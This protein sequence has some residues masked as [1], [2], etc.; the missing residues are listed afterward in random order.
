MKDI[1]FFLN[2]EKKF[3]FPILI[4]SF[5]PIILFLGS[6]VINFFIILLDL[7]FLIEIIKNK[8]LFLL[9][10][11][12]FYLLIVFWAILIINLY[13]SIDYQNSLGRSLGFI[14][15]IILIF[16]FQYY[17]NY[18]KCKYQNIVFKTWCLTFFIISIDLIYEFSFGK[19]IFGYSS[20]MPGRLAGFFNEELKIGYLYSSLILF[21][22]SYLFILFFKERKN[23]FFNNKNFFYFLIFFSLFVSFIIGERSNFL[24][25]LIMITFFIF[26]VDQKYIY[27]KIIILFSFF[28]ILFFIIL[29]SDSYKYRFWTMLIKPSIE[30]P[31]SLLKKSNYG[32]HYMVAIEVFKNNKIYGVGLKNYREEVKKDIYNKNSSIHPH[33]VHFEI[34]AELGLIGYFYFLIFFVITLFF[35]INSYF[36]EKNIYKLS[37]ILFVFVNL[38]PVIPTGSFFTTYTATIF[39]INF[40]IMLPN[41]V[42]LNK[43][44]FK[45][46]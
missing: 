5:F 20:Y 26:L 1:F 38:M 2:K 21:S 12:F 4:I 19:N 39:W 6:G 40:A 13:F 33:Q 8:R 9:K 42:L 27:R 29:N 34:L 30:K 41:N 25:A 11:I 18:M 24:K 46:E 10:N 15:F 45:S 37:A 16:A 3:N 44:Q 35:S 14:R 32:Q 31:V 28:L 22:L 36:K 23:I 17:L 43:L 7:I